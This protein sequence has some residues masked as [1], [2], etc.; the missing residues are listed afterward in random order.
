MVIINTIILFSFIVC[1]VARDCREWLEAGVID[2]GVYPINPDGT[3]PFQVLLIVC[4]F[5]K[6]I[7]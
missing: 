6:Y 2:S 7:S 3:T 1:P 5:I 4:V